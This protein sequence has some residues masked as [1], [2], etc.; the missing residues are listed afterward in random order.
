[1]ILILV[2]IL[3]NPAFSQNG[4]GTEF[5]VFD[6]WEGL[7]LHPAHGVRTYRLG[8][9]LSFKFANLD[10][11][12]MKEVVA[13]RIDASPYFSREQVNEIDAHLKD[14]RNKPLTESTRAGISN[15][16]RDILGRM[17]P[18]VNGIEMEKATRLGF[19]SGSTVADD[20]IHGVRFIIDRDSSDTIAWANLLKTSAQR[21]NPTITLGYKDSPTLPVRSFPTVIDGSG[22]RETVALLIE[23]YHTSTLA[24]SVAFVISIIA[25]LLWLA[26]KSEILR[27]TAQPMRPDG[28]Y[29][30][31]LSR[32]QM[33]FWFVT[34]VSSFLFLWVV[35][36]R[37][38]TLTETSLALIGIGSATALG[39]ALISNV[40]SDEAAE[41]ESKDAFQKYHSRKGRKWVV[42]KDEA[43]QRESDFDASLIALTSDPAAT[44]PSVTLEAEIRSEARFF[45][46]GWMSE[47]FFDW[48]TEGKVVSF[49][50]F[51]MMAWTLALG[52][53]FIV[54]VLKNLELPKFDGTLLALTGI[55]AGTYLGFKFPTRKPS[56]TQ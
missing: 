8:R 40:T 53:V 49:H 18:I 23:L 33:A 32:A 47:I 7:S 35:T 1:M 27:D 50:R 28:S 30:W 42:L 38:D 52:L 37:I 44:R 16:T 29:P 4:K 9:A 39:A 2:T 54:Q 22:S 19:S 45:K 48:L 34:V 20:T 12:I 51:Q 36:N 11:W 25:I 31:S 3:S 17:Y 43:L 24:L 10:G 55:S 56:G 14:K 26:P 15:Y 13:Q 6:A 41:Q 5:G 46:R 21:I